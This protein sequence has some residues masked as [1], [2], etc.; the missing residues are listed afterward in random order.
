LDVSDLTH[1]IHY[2]LPDDLETYTHRSGR[3]GRAGKTGISAAIIH[4]KEKGKI[5]Q[6]ER[7]INQPFVQVQVPSGLDICQKQMFHFID[8]IEHVQVD[9][10]AVENLLPSIYRKLEWL[11]KEELIKRMVHQQFNRLFDYYKKN[12]DLQ[13][14][15]EKAHKQQSERT[16]GKVKTQEAGFQKLYIGLGKAHGITPRLFMELINDYVDGRVQIGRIDF[17]NRFSLV[18]VE[19]KAA[20]RVVNALRSVVM[21]GKGLKVN[22]ASAFDLESAEKERASQHGKKQGQRTDYQKHSSYSGK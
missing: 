18:D 12:E 2:S 1:V 16:T 9:S 15:D 11:D 7:L 5:R 10:S 4:L 21:F 22:F 13:S 19:E 8:Q 20:K 17:Y 6:I 3:T 14:V